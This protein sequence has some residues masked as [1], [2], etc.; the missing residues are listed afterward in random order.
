M[1]YP[2]IPQ[3]FP[4]NSVGI[5]TARDHVVIEDDEKALKRR[6]EQFADDG[7]QDAF[8]ARSFDLKDSGTW[9]LKQARK[10]LFKESDLKSF[11]TEIL[12]RPFDIKHIFYHDAVIERSRKDVMKHMEKDNLALVTPRRV[13][14]DIPWTHSLIS[15]AIIEHV[16]VS[17]KTIDYCFP[18]FIYQESK[19]VG[20]VSGGTP[21]TK[22]QFSMVL[23]PELKYYVK[24]RT[25]NI[26]D[27]VWN[28]V[29]D[30]FGKFASPENIFY[31][32]YA[33]LYSPKYRKKYAEFLKTD[34]PRVPFT[35]DKQVFKELAEYGEVLV[36]MHLLK[37]TKLL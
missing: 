13:E 2:S 34:F 28:A 30:A 23:E 14:T 27:P 3:I 9:K 22:Y 35:A 36:E 4:V 32:I 15:D 6:I 17:L 29:T 12:Y 19:K 10:E 20:G 33:V 16:V 5:V 7:L 21:G 37:S 24:G 26:A 18:L 1:K 25:A 11:L 31:Y 8:I